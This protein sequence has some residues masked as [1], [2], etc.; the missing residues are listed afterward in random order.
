[1]N[2]LVQPVKGVISPWVV[3]DVS[4]ALIEVVPTAQTLLFPLI[5]VLM[6]LVVSSLM[7]TA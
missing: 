5:P 7:K 4:I 6:V 2:L 3:T 1:M